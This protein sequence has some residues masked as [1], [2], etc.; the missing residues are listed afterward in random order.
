MFYDNLNE[1][2]ALDERRNNII[3][4]REIDEDN[5]ENKD[6]NT[7]LEIEDS[8]NEELKTDKKLETV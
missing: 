8:E 6:D 4:I 5:Y 2:K 3:K 1:E 7:E